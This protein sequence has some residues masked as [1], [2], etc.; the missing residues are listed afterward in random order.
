LLSKKEV[1][2][3]EAASARN[4]DF[5]LAHQREFEKKLAI[6]EEVDL[7]LALGHQQ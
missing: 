7:K 6:Q 1:F 4:R 3:F 5:A 2:Q